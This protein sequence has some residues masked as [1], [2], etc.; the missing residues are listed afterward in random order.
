MRL[1]E[2]WHCNLHNPFRSRQECTQEEL[3][4]PPILVLKGQYSKFD[5]TP[6]HGDS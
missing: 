5:L 4:N 1:K 2:D 3:P 6:S